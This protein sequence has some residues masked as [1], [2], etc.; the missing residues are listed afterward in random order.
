M[1]ILAITAL[2]AVAALLGGCDANFHSIFRTTPNGTGELH[3]QLVYSDAKQAVSFMQV[4]NDN[5]LRACA[6][7][8]PDVFAALSTAFSGD[9]SAETAKL[10]AA[11]S[12]AGATSEQASAFGLRTQLTQ[13][14]MELLY[15]LCIASLNGT[16]SPDQFATEM[17]RYQ[18]TMVTMLAIEQVTGYAKPTVVVIGGNAAAG[19]ADALATTQAKIDDAAKKEAAA[20]AALD[21]AGTDKKAAGT[22]YDDAAAALQKA[23]DDKKP[24]ADIKAAQTKVDEADKTKKAA[25]EAVNKA[26]GDLKKATSYRES[27]E[28]L[29]AKQEQ[30]VNLSASSATPTVVSPAPT[31]DAASIAAVAATVERLQYNH[32]SQTFIADECLRYLFHPNATDAPNLPPPPGQYPSMTEILN[33]SIGS[34]AKPVTGTPT[35]PTAA[36]ISDLRTFC[37]NYLTE[38]AKYRMAYLNR[39]Y[40]C[41]DQGGQCKLP[42]VVT[43]KTTVVKGAPG[44]TATETTTTETPIAVMPQIGSGTPQAGSGTPQEPGIAGTPMVTQ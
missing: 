25:D 10:T 41:D 1:R 11:L 44:T 32:L 28:K 18:N 26:D 24:E 16:L 31:M 42:V 19:S 20:K 23:K 12:G 43:Q 17:H 9:V 36:Q 15:Q 29:L 2:C 33:K 37:A 38:T 35:P 13:S 3:S 22:A 8:S 30:E 34:T 14:Q 4:G 40:G 5:V 6:A 27:L 21:K 7:R 39:Y